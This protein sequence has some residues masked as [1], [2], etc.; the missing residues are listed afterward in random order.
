MTA[1]QARE[2]PRRRCASL[3]RRLVV[4]AFG[5]TGN[6]SDEHPRNGAE[7]PVQRRGRVVVVLAR[8]GQL[9]LGVGEILLQIQEVAR[10]VQLRIALAESQHR[11][12]RGVELLFCGAA[13]RDG[14][15]R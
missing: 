4:L 12:K 9:A 15:S 8:K 11:R 5:D 10:R 1:A 13:L 2:Y 14:R 7:K 6:W 3:P